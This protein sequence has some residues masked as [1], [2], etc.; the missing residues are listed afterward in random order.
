MYIIESGR[1]QRTSTSFVVRTSSASDG[2][3]TSKTYLSPTDWGQHEQ[4]PSGA[5]VEREWR[6]LLKLQLYRCSI[7]WPVHRGKLVCRRPD[8]YPFAPVV[9]TSPLPQIYRRLKRNPDDYVFENRGLVYLAFLVPSLLGL[10][11]NPRVQEEGKRFWK[12][13]ET[14]TRPSADRWVFVNRAVSPAPMSQE[15][16]LHSIFWPLP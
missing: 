12:G 14:C 9:G 8:R 7:G 16:R 4:Q 2:T 11:H 1:V 13:D 10:P 6:V 15:T 5:H 3:F